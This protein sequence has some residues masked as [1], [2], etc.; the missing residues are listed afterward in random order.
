MRAGAYFKKKQKEREDA[1]KAA[2]QEDKYHKDF[3]SFSKQV[4]EGTLGQPAVKP[5]FSQPEAD[6]YFPAKYSTTLKLD[7]GRLNW[8]PYIPVGNVE[9]V[10]FDTLLK[11]KG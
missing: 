9:R 6:A 8:F 11:I 3:W 5:T 1:K 4:C 7:T 2:F 10:D